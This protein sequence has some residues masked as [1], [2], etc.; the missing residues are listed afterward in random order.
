MAKT[1]TRLPS[2]VKYVPKVSIKVLFP[3]PGTPVIPIRMDLLACGKHP[4]IMVLACS[5]CFGFLLS[6]KVIA[7]L[8][9]GICPFKIEEIKVSVLNIFPNEFY[10]LTALVREYV[11]LKSKKLKY[12]C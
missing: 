2:D 9:A 11:L 6:I 12:R 10:R 8:S 1:A 4:F 5:K 3:T 7:L